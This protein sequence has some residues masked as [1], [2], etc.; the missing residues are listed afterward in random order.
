MSAKVLSNQRVTVLAGLASSITNWSNI[1]LSELAALKNVSGAVNWDSFDI[2]LQASDQNDDRTLTDGAGAQSRGYTNFG[3]TIEL[4]NPAVTD[5]AGVYR[6]AYNIFSTQRVELVVALRYGPSNAT[7]PAAGDEWFIYHVITD[8][9]AFGQGDVSKYY[10]VTLV[11]RDD[12]LPAYIV[13]SASPTA[14]ALTALAATAAVGELVLVS[15]AYKGWDVTKAVEYEVSDATLLQE[16][17]PGIFLAVAA[18]APTIT[19]KYPGA[20]SATPLPITVS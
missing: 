3:G 20:T 1:P 10:K 17:H 2:N 18:G 13:P 4:V 15:A 6:E 12:V 7:A 8:A 11:A 9:V 19:A 14:I 16:V 5:L